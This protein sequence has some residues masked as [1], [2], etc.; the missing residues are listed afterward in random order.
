MRPK[1]PLPIVLLLT[2]FGASQTIEKSSPTDQNARDVVTGVCIHAENPEFPP[3]LPKKKAR[4]EIVLHATITTDGT[5]K[6]VTVVSGDPILTGPAI[7]A[8]RQWR[9]V[10]SIKDGKA[11][12]SH[13]I[14][15]VAYILG[16]GVSL[17]EDAAPDVPREPQE[18]V[19]QEVE[20]GEVFQ[21]M[22]HCV[23]FPKAL[24]APNPEYSEAAKKTKFEGDVLL[25]VLVGT[26]GRPRSTWIVHTL[27]R[28]LDEKAIEAV[29]QWRF[30][31]ST[32]D[33]EPVA[34][35]IN[36]G[37]RFQLR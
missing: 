1:I 2:V 31:P 29:R 8:V 27:G 25:G 10:P 22:C 17:P 36:L 28:G 6:D 16:N 19:I 12:E 37:L 23:T 4:D 7:E 15:K 3:G 5:V 35:V 30:Q 24:Y 9:Y 11:V 34:V 20:R 13:S 14:I 21:L 18:D 26:D 33:G 32:K